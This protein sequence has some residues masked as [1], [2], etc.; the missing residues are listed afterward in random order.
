MEARTPFP[1]PPGQMKPRHSFRG[2]G[3]LGSLTVDIQSSG[4]NSGRR[5]HH[6]NAYPVV[7]TS[8]F[9]NPVAC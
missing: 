9:T 4:R 2:A 6:L 7:Q 5:P 1:I 8:M 3:S